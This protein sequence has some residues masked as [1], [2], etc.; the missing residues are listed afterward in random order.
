MRLSLRTSI[1]LLVFIVA[2]TLVYRVGTRPVS[3]SPGIA[4]SSV[5]KDSHGSERELVDQTPIPIEAIA[6]FQSWMADYRAGR[7]DAAF[8]RQGVE[9]ASERRGS[10]LSLM[11]RDSRAALEVAIGYADYASLPEELQALLEEPFTATGDVE[12]IAICDHDY[13]TPE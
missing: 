12:V 2:L 5:G 9:I 6:D 8:L 7:R 3:E 11:Q 4:P 1:S 10:M 13:H